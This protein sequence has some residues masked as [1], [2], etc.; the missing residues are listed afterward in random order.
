M[1][2]NDSLFESR[3]AL[4]LYL[5]FWMFPKCWILDLFTKG[6]H[7]YISVFH[8]KM[9]DEYECNASCL[10]AFFFHE[11]TTMC[12]NRHKMVTFTKTIIYQKQDQKY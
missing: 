9:M 11:R 8:I 6:T 1:K 2:E 10:V 12:I 7:L 3:G 4:H 5:S